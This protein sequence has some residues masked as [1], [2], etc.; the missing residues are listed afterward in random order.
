MKGFYH[1]LFLGIDESQKPIYEKQR[2]GNFLSISKDIRALLSQERSRS[3]KITMSK[4]YEK[5]FE[6]RNITYDLSYS[7]DFKDCNFN[8]ENIDTIIKYGKMF[9]GDAEDFFSEI[10]VVSIPLI[11]YYKEG[12]K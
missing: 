3:L 6:Y 1:S 8:S 12:E 7:N 11:S 10:R 9:L 4:E 2:Y 5:L